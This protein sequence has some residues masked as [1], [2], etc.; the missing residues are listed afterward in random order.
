MGLR[1]LLIEFAAAAANLHP[2]H[3]TTYDG[4]VR[5]DEPVVGNREPA[6]QSAFTTVNA[7]SSS[8]STS[9]PSPRSIST[10]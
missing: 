8:T 6:D 7:P 9:L 3:R 10:S 1:R 4:L 2:D 5:Q